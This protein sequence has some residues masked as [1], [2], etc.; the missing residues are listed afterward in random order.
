MCRYAMTSYKPHYACFNCRKTFKRRLLQDV[1]GGHGNIGETPAKCPECGDVMADIGLDF[2]SPKKKDLKAWNHISKLY[3]VDITFHSCG[4]QGPGFIP[5][6]TDEMIE[7]FTRIKQDY[8]SHQRF[9]SRRKEDP[10]TQSEIARD[11]HE[12]NEFLYALPKEMKNGTKNK[13]KYNAD[14]AQVYWGERIAAIEKKIEI[15]TKGM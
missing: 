14:E 2:E 15:V 1:M 6:D 9:W 11:K 10:E 13:P 8:L 7:H 12:N 3:Q 5:S 4:C